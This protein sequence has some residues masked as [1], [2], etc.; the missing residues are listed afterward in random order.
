MTGP[1][2]SLT[3]VTKAF[4]SK[5][6]LDGVD[7]ELDA[8][9]AAS[10]VGP[11]GSG[12]STLLSILGLMMTPDDGRYV[13]D[14]HDVYAGSSRRRAQLRGAR[15][16][17]V[18]Q[19]FH[20]IRASTVAENLTVPLAY[21]SIPLRE[22]PRLVATMLARVGMEHAATQDVRTLSGG[23]QQRVAV[24]RA[25]IL[26]PAVLL[27]DEPTGNLDAANAALILELLLG[28]AERGGAVVVITHD[29]ELAARLDRRLALDAGILVESS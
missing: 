22:R 3:G 27:C 9:Q 5:V 13:L 14:G 29:Q 26:D 20:L 16:G 12:K 17:F 25:M 4:G 2:L 28:H 21:Q 11:S 6:V 10:V 8:G 7:F 19:Q 1:A 24:A 15:L 18:F 23:E